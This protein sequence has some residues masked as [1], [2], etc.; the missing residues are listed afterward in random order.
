M[1]SKSV[2][3]TGVLIVLALGIL[4]AL[5]GPV[6]AE[7]CADDYSNWPCEDG[8]ERP[9]LYD[10]P[11][12]GVGENVSDAGGNVTEALGSLSDLGDALPFPT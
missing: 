4:T 9:P 8:E 2:V 11:E 12:P 3:R 6:A 10:G 1:V 5:A 7:E